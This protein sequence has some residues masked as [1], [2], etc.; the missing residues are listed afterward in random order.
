LATN[1][2]FRLDNPPEDGVAMKTQGEIEAAI[3]EGVSPHFSPQCGFAIA[4]S[5]LGRRS[6]LAGP[7]KDKVAAGSRLR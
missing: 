3:C 7:M 2:D 5:A 4:E 6:C 1:E